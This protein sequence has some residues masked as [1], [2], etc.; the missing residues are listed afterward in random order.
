MRTVREVLRLVF[1]GLSKR[2]V[3]R[4][5]GL[6][7]TTVQRLG[8]SSQHV[9]EAVLDHLYGHKAG[10]ADVYNR[11]IYAVEKRAALNLW[12]GYLQGIISEEPE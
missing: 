8:V 11:S 7:S 4:R 3:A 9:V 5:T 2:E 12:A 10:I 6:A 1:A